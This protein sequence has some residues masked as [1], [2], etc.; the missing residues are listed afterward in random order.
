MTSGCPNK[1]EKKAQA[2][3]DKQGN[4]KHQMSKEEKAQQKKRCYLCRERGHM[5]NSCFLGNNSKLIIIDANIMLRKDG[6][7]Y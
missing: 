1:L 5:A 7:S 4:E 3:Y 2:N 6:Y